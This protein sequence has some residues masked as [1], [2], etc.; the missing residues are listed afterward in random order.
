M[1]V[2]A[3]DRNSGERIAGVERRREAAAKY[4]PGSVDLLLV[5]EA[6][7]SNGDRYFY[8]E[9]VSEQDS[10]FR[11]VAKSLLGYVPDRGAKSIALGHLQ[12]KGVFLIDL[13]EIPADTARLRDCVPSLVE[14]CSALEPRKIVL[15]KVNVFDLAY[16]ALRAAGLPVA[17][18]RIP[19]PGSGQQRRFE[20]AFSRAL[21]AA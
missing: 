7:P 10:L 14:R 16:L 3:D 11:Y 20:K 4:R 1:K 19:F 13:S 6:P 9:N 17:N 5:A 2:L 15:I 8:F 18:V 21:E 12:A